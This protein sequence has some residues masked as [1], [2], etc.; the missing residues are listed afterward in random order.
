MMYRRNWFIF[1]VLDNMCIEKMMERLNSGEFKTIFRNISST[2]IIGLTTSGRAAWQ[3]EEDTTKDTSI[4][5][6][7]QEK[8]FTSE[9]SMV[10]QDGILLILHYRTMWLFRATSSSRFIIS[11]VQSIYILSSGLIPGG[12]HLSKRHTVF[13]TSVDP[14]D[15]NHKDPDTIDW[16]V[17]RLAWY[18]QK[19]W[20]KHQIA[21]YGVE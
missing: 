7:L 14:M 6:M 18:H 19:K 10:I 13:F 3:E 1:F 11:D 21:V 5:L 16:S 4:V 8:F 2:V 20:K 12:Q 9:L 15:K 17:P